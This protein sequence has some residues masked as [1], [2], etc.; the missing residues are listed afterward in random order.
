MRLSTVVL[1]EMIER[2]RQLGA[3]LT[4][5]ILG[6]A[7]IVSVRN[8]TVFSQMAVAKEL[9]AL[10]A[11]I[12][13]LPKSATIQGYYNADLQGEE[14]PEEYVSRLLL[15]DLEG[16]DNLSP[17]LS[18]PV[19]VAGASLILTG[20]L[21]RSEFAAKATWSGAG[22]FSRPAGCGVVTGGEEAAPARETL[23]RR[24]VIETLEEDELIAGAEAAAA[25]GI[26]EGDRLSI[27]GAE[28]RV[29]A[30][31]PSTGTVDDSRLIAHLHKVQE[32]TGK[33]EVVSAIEVVGCC[34]EIS[35]GLVAKINRTLPD[36]KVV[37]VR[38]VVDVQIRTNRLMR[39]LS[40]LLIV[41]LLFVGGAAIANY[42][43]ANVYERR[44]EIGTIMALGGTSGTIL[45]LFLGK[46]L[47]LGA[48]GGV[49]GFIVGTAIAV[50]IGP[51]IARVPVLPM[52]GLLLPALLLAAA[53]AAAAS[54]LPARRASRLDP[55]AALQ[56]I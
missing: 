4:A 56:E 15:S 9:D 23:V 1:H 16:L 41:V 43:Y 40:A 47:L 28:F 10:G 31:L 34:N 19:D 45:R 36:A 39:R 37:T 44:R 12:L 13:I 17:K 48:A 7:L 29:T 53:T 49:G 32:L 33:G 30:V 2:K 38:Q 3:S 5:V 20:I 22:I 21:P 46:A 27:L 25:A 42:M 24:R 51:K 35:K 50:V 18:V 54:F 55:S 11:N 14:I 8:I 26:G 6:I 52:P